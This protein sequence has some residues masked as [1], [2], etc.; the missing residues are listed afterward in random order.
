MLIHA[1]SGRSQKLHEV[2]DAVPWYHSKLAIQAY[3]RELNREK[4]VIEYTFFQPGIF[5]EYLVAPHQFSKH[6][7]P[8]A[9]M[10]QLSALRI[11]SVR[12]H[13]DDPV[14]FTS[15]TDIARVVR[16]AIEYDGKWPEIGGIT[17][18][19]LSARDMQQ[20]LERVTGAFPHPSLRPQ[21]STRALTK[22]MQQHR[23]TGRA[24]IGRRG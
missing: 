5:L 7:V 16:H 11:A 6:V 13:E 14:V 1:H 12:G 8:V 19:R 20:M 2:I 15:A 24:C 23:Q 17:G 21:T 18:D 9:S 22:E 4:Q 3:L 10:Y